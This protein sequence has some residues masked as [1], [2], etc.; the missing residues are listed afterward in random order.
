MKGKNRNT[1]I[2]TLIY[3]ILPLSL[4]PPYSFSFF[5]SFVGQREAKCIVV[6]LVRFDDDLTDSGLRHVSY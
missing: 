3:F 2:A 6:V 5:L 1:E 4:S